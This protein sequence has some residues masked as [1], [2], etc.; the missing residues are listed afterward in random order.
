MVHRP[1]RPV[2]GLFKVQKWR[3]KSENVHRNFYFIIQAFKIN[4]SSFFTFRY[5]QFW[6]FFFFSFF[7][8]INEDFFC[9]TFFFQFLFSCILPYTLRKERVE[10]FSDKKEDNFIQFLN[11]GGREILEERFRFLSLLTVFF[12]FLFSWRK[13]SVMCLK[14]FEIQLN[15][16]SFVYFS[17]SREFL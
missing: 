1:L 2:R 10:L 11:K 12:S 6:T 7:I 8:K 14:C 9:R 16:S 5:Y 4:F 15:S 13:K 3:Q 17:V